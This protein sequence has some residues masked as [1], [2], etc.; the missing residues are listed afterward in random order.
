M[1]R[2]IQHVSVPRPRGPEANDRAV[3]FYEGILG[4]Q[5]VPCPETLVHLDITWFRWGDDE[6]H[7][8]SVAPDEALPVQGA[9]FC[10]AVDD[11]DATRT[12][13]EAAGVVCQE[14]DPIPGRPRFFIHDPFDNRI[15]IS[16][17]DA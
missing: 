13:L 8:F 6:I 15:E 12:Q 7:V 5:H 4:A 16:Q 17:I 10:M 11:I 3:A 2:R 9:H 1:T 14:T